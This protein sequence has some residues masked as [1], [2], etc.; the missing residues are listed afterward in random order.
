[1][2]FALKPL[3]ADYIQVIERIMYLRDT[4]KIHTSD[5]MNR[6]W[7]PLARMAA[8]RAMVGTNSIEGINVTLDDA[9]AVVDGEAPTTPQ[10]ENYAAL[11]GYWNAM[12]YIVQLSK[13]PTYVHNENTIKGLHYMMLG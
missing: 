6:W 5:S 7:G 2:I 4:L 10:G 12:T 8:A 1:M 3:P 11:R 9:V 13:D